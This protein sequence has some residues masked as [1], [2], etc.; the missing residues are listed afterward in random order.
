MN[1]L[2]FGLAVMACISLAIMPAVADDYT[3]DIFGNANM[4]DTIDEDDVAY[5]EGIIEGI[6]D[7]TELADA[8]YDGQI[9]EADIAQ[10]ELIIAGEEKELTIIDYTDRIVTVS[11]PVERVI[12]LNEYCADA[13]QML[14]VQNKIVGVSNP[15][16]EYTYLPELS[17][18]PALGMAKDPDLEAIISLDPDLLITWW[19]PTVSELAETLPDSVTVVDLS[20]TKPENLTDELMMLGYI[21]G[22]RDDASRYID[23]FHGKYIGLI[24]SR[25]EELS[26]EERPK[27]YVEC[28]KPYKTYGH[29]T[30]AHQSINLVG[31]RNIFSDLEGI[32]VVDPEAILERNPDVI[33][34]GAYT[35]AG[36]EVEDP[37][38]L[39]DLRDEI[40]SR[41]EFADI[42]A[43][44]DGK[45]YMVDVNLHYGLD[46]LLGIVHWAKI[47]HPDLFVDLNPHEIHQEYLTAYLG[48]DFDLDEKGVF[49]YPPL[50]L[51]V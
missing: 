27:V 18:L 4:D 11:K 5:V 39:A 50:E 42:T 40:M 10:I 37:S 34:V 48:L 2:A 3:L 49:V 36:Y 6:N 35:D 46:Y 44:K 7:A 45:V 14:G 51:T 17:T 13:L 25:T 23:D 1:R 31:G 21:F 20:F 29:T 9:D 33:I 12:L 43:V 8:N 41:P 15:V 38:K 26:D 47:I 28:N 16:T 24:K 32:P 22:K 19:S 30:G